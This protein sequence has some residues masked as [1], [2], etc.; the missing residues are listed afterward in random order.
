MSIDFSACRDCLCLDA[1]RRARAITR[2]YEG[3]LRPFG[4]RATQFSI[5]SALAIAG[6]RR[7][8]DLADLLGL[9]RTTL[10]R[11]AAV[12]IAQ[13]W[14]DSPVS[15]DARQRR[16]RLTKSG[17]R[18]LESAFPAWKTAQDL[19]ISEFGEASVPQARA[20]RRLERAA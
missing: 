5:L 11:G 4:L 1:R 16:L 3:Y 20:G 9:E 10:S 19:A 14:I 12:L 6:P 7:I 2:H 17:R 15:D 13:G 18:K 8:G